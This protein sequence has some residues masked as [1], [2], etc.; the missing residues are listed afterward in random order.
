[1]EVERAK[2]PLA[3]HEQGTT[4]NVPINGTIIESPHP[5]FKR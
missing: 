4:Y 1:M 5:L 2:Q 3:H